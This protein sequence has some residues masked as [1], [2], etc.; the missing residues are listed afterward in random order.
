MK[1]STK[2]IVKFFVLFSTLILVTSFGFILKLRANEY[3]KYFGD[4]KPVA[5]S[6]DFHRLDSEI[7]DNCGGKIEDIGI[8]IN[9]V[10]SDDRIKFSDVF[11]SYNEFKAVEKE[12]FDYAL[13]FFVL[14]ML[15][16]GI[17]ITSIVLLV[18]I[19]RGTLTEE[20][21]K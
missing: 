18:R 10:D 16:I 12:V 6:V 5:C 1:V 4:Y 13:K 2:K 7:C 19:H 15:F 14:F 20:D 11:N 17:T 8:F 3:F 9:R 21:L